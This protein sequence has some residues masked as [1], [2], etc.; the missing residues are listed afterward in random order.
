MRIDEAKQILSKNGYIVENA[1]TISF[2]QE[3]KTLYILMV[4]MNTV[5][6]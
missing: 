2:E 6:T 5:L 3:A 4:Q 1:D